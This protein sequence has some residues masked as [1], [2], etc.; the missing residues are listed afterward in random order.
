MALPGIKQVASR[1]LSAWLRPASQTDIERR[2]LLVAGLR[3]HV[4]RSSCARIS[5]VRSEMK[6]L[7]LGGATLALMSAAHLSPALAQT[8]S[9]KHLAAHF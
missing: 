3:S 9:R 2:L 4:T 1:S 8:L 7:L 5:L 6:H